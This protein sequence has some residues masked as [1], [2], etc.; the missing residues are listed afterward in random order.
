MSG[1]RN[2]QFDALPSLDFSLR[3]SPAAPLTRRAITSTAPRLQNIFI[4]QNITPL[5]Q[6]LTAFFRIKQNTAPL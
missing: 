4:K 5:L 6:F 2:M 3:S 1:E